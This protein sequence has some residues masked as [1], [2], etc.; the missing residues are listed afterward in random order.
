MSKDLADSNDTRLF[1]AILMD[2]FHTNYFRRDVS[3]ANQTEVLWKAQ[4]ARSGRFMN[5]FKRRNKTLEYPDQMDYI[6]SRSLSSK[7]NIFSYLC[8]NMAINTYPTL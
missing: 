4:G 3:V 1:R 5:S 8:M 2:T 6:G 7:G